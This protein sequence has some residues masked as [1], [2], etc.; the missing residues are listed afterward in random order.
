MLSSAEVGLI[1]SAFRNVVACQG[2]CVLDKSLSI[3]QTLSSLPVDKLDNF[4]DLCNLSIF[5]SDRLLISNNVQASLRLFFSQSLGY[6]ASGLLVTILT[7]VRVAGAAKNR[8]KI[9]RGRLTDLEH[10]TA[11]KRLQRLFDAILLTR[12]RPASYYMLM[13]L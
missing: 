5:Q 1:G 13:R 12:H 2:G 10:Q 4:L 6:R 11:S 3:S 9:E 8:I 7:Q